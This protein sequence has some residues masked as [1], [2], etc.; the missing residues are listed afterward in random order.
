MVRQSGQRAGLPDRKDKFLC[1]H[2]ER[3]W[4]VAGVPERAPVSNVV[5]A[6][7]ALKPDVVRAQ[8]RGKKGKRKKM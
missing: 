8:E 7:E 3:H 5:T 2:D 6:M 4:F 1:G